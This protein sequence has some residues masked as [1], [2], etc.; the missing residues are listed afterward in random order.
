MKKSNL[1]MGIPA[2]IL[3]FGMTAVGCNNDSTDDNNNNGGGGSGGTFTLT[4]I[5]AEYNGKYAFAF[6]GLSASDIS[7]IIY[8]CQKVN[9]SG[10]PSANFTLCKISNGSVNLPLWK[11]NGAGVV[12]YTGDDTAVMIW[13]YIYNSQTVSQTDSGNGSIKA[14][15]FSGVAFSNGSATKSWNDGQVRR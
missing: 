7:D 13:G 2:I 9:G 4:D 1:W 5:P 12:R 10:T 11:Q 6:I 8:G 3:V 15:S 14:S